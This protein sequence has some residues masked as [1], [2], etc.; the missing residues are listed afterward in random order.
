M[1]GKKKKNSAARNRYWES[2]RLE[3]KKV[4]NLVRHCGMSEVDAL[5][6]WRSARNLKATKKPVMTGPVAAKKKKAA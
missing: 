4:R 3:R 2:G 5:K 6:H 1:A